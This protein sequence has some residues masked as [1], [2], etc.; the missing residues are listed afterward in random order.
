MNNLTDEQINRAI[1]EQIMGECWHELREGVSAMAIQTVCTQCRDWIDVLH[2]NS[3]YCTD[4]NAVA[5]AE[6]VVIEQVG[7]EAYITALTRIAPYRG[8]VASARQRAEACLKAMEIK[9]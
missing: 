7:Y 2:P 6:A 4:L 1:H 3:D 9:I 8:F 5:Q